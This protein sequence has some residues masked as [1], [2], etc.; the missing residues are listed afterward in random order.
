[1]S[2]SAIIKKSKIMEIAKKKG[3]PRVKPL[4][5]AMRTQNKLEK[6]LE[7]AYGDQV[8]QM[9]KTSYREMKRQF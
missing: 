1:M 7:N 8:E 4:I 3:D 5:E 9:M 2:V 6:E